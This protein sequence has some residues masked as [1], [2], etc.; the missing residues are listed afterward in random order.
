MARVYSLSNQ[1][2]QRNTL[3]R[4]LQL[5]EQEIISR[6]FKERIE[7]AYDFLMML[8][9]K[10]Q[11]HAREANQE[12]SNEIKLTEMSELDQNRLKKV[13]AVVGEVQGRI[14]T[15]FNL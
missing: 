7:N 6:E 5:Y 10:S 2:C 1:I 4:L 15:D 13:L 3:S 9:F 11:L 14:K 8:R 12:P